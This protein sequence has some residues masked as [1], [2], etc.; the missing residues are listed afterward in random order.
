MALG[1]RASQVVW[2]FLRRTLLQ[3][4]IGL[5]L[6]LPGAL[7]VG[8]LLQGFLL[9][10][11]P[12]DPITLVVI[13]LLLAVIALVAAALPTRRATRIDPMVALRYE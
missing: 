6:G 7:G 2:L 5:M 10:T 9:R 3:L 12:R 4:A 1:A 8:Q 11:S 13:V